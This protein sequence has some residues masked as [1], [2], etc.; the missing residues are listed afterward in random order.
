MQPNDLSSDF[1]YFCR[2]FWKLSCNSVAVIRKYSPH[3]IFAEK[4][5]VGLWHGPGLFSSPYSTTRLQGTAP[6]DLSP[7]GSLR[8]KPGWRS[9]GL[10]QLRTA[11][12][13]SF[14][15][16]ILHITF[17]F[18]VTWPAS[19]LSNF[20]Y[21]WFLL[22]ALCYR[23]CSV[24]K[25]HPTLCDPMDCRTSGFPVLHYLSAFAQTLV[26]WVGDAI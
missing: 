24:T 16:I 15:V 17:F 8:R 25:S 7:W 13:S 9:G 19:F 12:S 6:F 21:V 10:L 3:L 26:H 5:L 1:S 2:F 18:S 22:S 23:C 14:S 4:S 11:S 20:G